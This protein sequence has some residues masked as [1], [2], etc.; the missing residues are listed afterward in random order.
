MLIPTNS[1]DLKGL[2]DF[3]TNQRVQACSLAAVAKGSYKTSLDEMVTGIDASLAKLP[4]D[5]AAAD[6]TM[7]SQMCSIFTLLAQAM[8]CS[9]LSALELTKAT[10]SEQLASVMTA[11]IAKR[12]SAG[13][14]FTKDQH[15]AGL[16]SER[17][18]H[19]KTLTDS[20]ELVTK[21]AVIQLCSDSKLAGFT[22]GETK[23]REALLAATTEATLITTRKASLQAAS[24][25][26]PEASIEKLVLTGTDE[27]FA[28]RKA[29]FET[30]QADLKKEGIQL[31]SDGALANLWLDEAPYT[32]FRKLVAD[33]PQLKFQANPFA[34]APGAPA[35]ALVSAY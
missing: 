22:E 16:I 5:D 6:W 24:L 25:P 29:L 17:V 30:R 32:G 19:V 4:A 15:D 2:R 9:T 3:L 7:E 26:L 10:G 11:E 20:G 12:V 28:A 31:N 23:S 34:V 21:A 35:P 1:K 18:K 14:L 13:E 8:S 27:V 33:L